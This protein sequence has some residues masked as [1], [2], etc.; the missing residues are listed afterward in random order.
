MEFNENATLDDSLVNT[1]VSGGGGRGGGMV[2]GGTG[3]IIVLILSLVFGFNPGD[4]LGAE[5]QQRQPD[6]VAGQKPQCRTGADAKSNRECR[7]VAYMNGLA[8]FWPTQLDGA[9]SAKMQPFK[10]SVN[11]AC[12]AATSAVGPFYCPAD[13]LIYLDT[14]F[15]DDLQRR[16]GAQGGDAAEAYVV[17]HEYGHHI[18]NLTG[19][20]EIAQRDRS[21]GP[22][23]AGVR[24]E[25]Q[26]D[27]YAGV[28]L[29]H[30]TEGPNAQIKS[31]SQDDLNRAVDAA[32][33]VG[34]D[35]IQQR[36]TG[37]VDR[38][39]W[40][41]GSAKMRQYWLAQGFNTGNARQCDTFAANAPVG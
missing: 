28:W 10:G 30:A 36:A 21:T 32:K 12:G 27:C 13:R 40:T 29:S 31:L 37:R 20:M 1:T 11:T 6:I 2:I 25:L 26:A 38:E 17:A 18:Q 8:T 14:D 35:K 4:I 24:L 22:D 23:S 39:S 9:T 15:F 16:F 7:F 33:A 41:H 34:D 5:P 19:Q 3:G